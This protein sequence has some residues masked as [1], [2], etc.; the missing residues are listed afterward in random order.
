MKAMKMLKFINE[1]QFQIFI[2]AV[3][4]LT[5]IS[6]GQTDSTVVEQY[7]RLQVQGNKIVDK[8]GAPAAVRG[9][10][11]FWSQWSDGSKYYNE[12]CIGWLR[13]DWK[14]GIVRASMAVEFG[15]YLSN[16]YVEKEKIKTV[17]DACIDLGIYVI[18]D[19][20]DHNAHNHESEA[21][22]F[23]AE[24]AS[25]YGDYPNVIYEIYNEPEQVSWQN[26]VKPYAEA[27]IDTIRS[28]DPDNLIVVG[29]PTWSQDVD[30]A[31]G[32]PI[33]DN[34]TAYALHFYAA[35]HTQWLRNKAA[36]ALNNGIAL[37]AT[38]WGTCN[39]DA[40]G[41]VDTVQTQAW[42]SFMDQNMISWC[43]WSICDKEE[44]AAALKPGAG[45]TGGWSQEELSESGMFVREK[46]IDWYE[47]MY[48]ALP[49]KG[50]ALIKDFELYQNFPNPFNPVTTIRYT[51][52]A[53]T[54]A[55]FRHVDLTVY[56]I[57]GQKVSA[58]VS[59]KQSA[60]TYDVKFDAAGLSSGV[61]MC[62]LSVDNFKEMKKMILIR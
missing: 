41:K 22:Q 11:L 57:A 6:Y 33:A 7:G 27:V 60:G 55:D 23:F 10:S 34:N 48:T 30:V 2:M 49:E 21:K 13:D 29:T 17:V 31:S 35:S 53:H 4:I 26:V 1:S 16:P 40:Q 3:I 39:Y 25:D 18:I 9:M 54:P 52:G 15:G 58:L 59:Q 8:T 38:E 62:V 19:W 44:T 61:Y 14:C 43:N 45:S 5:G 51:V 46:I 37:F 12:S 42:W 32:S 56:N 47:N 36:T 28:I 20:H 50:Q 24:M